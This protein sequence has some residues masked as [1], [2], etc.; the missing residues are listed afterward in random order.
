MGVRVKTRVR[1]K[2]GVRVKTRVRVKTGVTV[3]MREG[4]VLA[5][6]NFR[7]KSPTPSFH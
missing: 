3:K 1:V 6:F 4:A 7:R 5:M 2:T